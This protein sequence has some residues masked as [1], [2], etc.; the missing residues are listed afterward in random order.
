MAN[1]GKSNHKQHASGKKTASGKTGGS[2]VQKQPDKSVKSSDSMAGKEASTAKEKTASK[3]ATGKAKEKTA[4]IITTEIAAA[5]VIVEAAEKQKDVQT[6]EQIQSGAS[7]LKVGQDG[8]LPISLVGGLLGMLVS[9][10]PATIWMILFKS[11]FYPLYLLI[12]VFIY[13]GITLFRGCR[14]IRAVVLTG[15]FSLAGAYLTSVSCQAAAYVADYKMSPVNIP[16]VVADLI[17]KKEALVD[18]FFSSANILPLTF[19][20]IGFL[21]A[22]LFFRY[23]AADFADE[24]AAGHKHQQGELEKAE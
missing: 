19:T 7:W 15:F 21:V 13:G 24:P 2:A 1:K 4:A 11:L 22:M 14:D 3:A 20:I 17:G 10:L 8:L 18:P 6:A 23:N 16:L 12:P 9:I 5:E